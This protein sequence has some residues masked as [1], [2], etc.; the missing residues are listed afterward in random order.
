LTNATI[1]EILVFGRKATSLRIRQTPETPVTDDRDSPP[2]A[3]NAD[4]RANLRLHLDGVMDQYD[5]INEAD[6]RWGESQRRGI[7]MC[8]E[9]VCT[10]GVQDDR[11]RQREVRG[12]GS[13]YE[14]AF[15]DAEAKGF[16][17]NGIF[18]GT[19]A[20]NPLIRDL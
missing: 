8:L 5:A 13:S 17:A 4:A 12:A 6:R 9:K 19:P 18:A 14:A 2:P 16:V 11:T 1:K 3:S 7:A 15:R 20:K 10:V